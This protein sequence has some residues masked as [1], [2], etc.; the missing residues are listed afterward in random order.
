MEGEG[1]KKFFLFFFFKKFNSSFRGTFFFSFFFLFCDCVLLTSCL[2][3]WA[4]SMISFGEF[5]CAFWE[6]C[7]FFNFVYLISPYPFVLVCLLDCFLVSC[8]EQ[9]STAL[10]LHCIHSIHCFRSSSFF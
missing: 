2:L 4:N 6:L 3:N 7:V 1:L 9:E 10:A 8:M 5:L